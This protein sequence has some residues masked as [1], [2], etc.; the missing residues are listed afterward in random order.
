MFYICTIVM[1]FT[2]LEC[3]NKDIYI[4]YRTRL[5]KSTRYVQIKTIKILL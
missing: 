2:V 5:T 1:P 4:I 3:V